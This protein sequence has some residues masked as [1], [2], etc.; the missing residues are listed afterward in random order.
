MASISIN[1]RDFRREV[2]GALAADG[3][4]WE[5]PE[6]V[7]T[8]S[9]KKEIFWR[10]YVRIISE[11]DYDI[12]K[13]NP[14]YVPDFAPIDDV[15]FDSKPMEGLF[16]WINV[17]SGMRGGKI[18]KTVPTI[19]R[20]GKNLGRVSATNPWTQALRDAYSTYN[21]QLKKAAGPGGVNVE[22]YP[23]MLAQVFNDQ[24]N[25]PTIDETHEA[26]VQRKYNGVRVVATLDVTVEGE[27]RVIMYSRR[28]G[29]YPGFT[30]IKA[31]LL[32]ILK[33]YHEEGR[34]LYID[35]ELYKHGIPLQD[36]SG[37][38]RREHR[39]GDPTL[40]YM[41]YDCF[42]SNEPELRFSERMKIRD[43]IFDEFDTEYAVSAETFTVNSHEEITRLYEQFLAEEEEGAM[44][45]FDE[46]YEYS[47][48]ERH[49]KALLK[50]KPTYD[51]EYKI[52]G[53]ETGT[54]G[55][56][57]NALMM[58]CETAEGIPFPVT[59]AA[60][61]PDRIAL[62]RKMT[63]VEP[64]GR[65]HFQNQWES[66]QLI[67]YFDEKSKDNVPQRARTKLEIRAWD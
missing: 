31:E 10:I 30:Y 15:Y 45:R 43:F 41:V 48:N 5:F 28:K 24:K 37:Y 26:F 18:K 34:R 21:R 51:E 39:A 25:L 59:P 58:I 49:C 6:V 63:E 7:S 17:Y 61:I 44:I 4:T 35:G 33:F 50:M 62:A 38:A 1:V 23:P 22:L 54:K 60:E 32:E 12:I 27:P 16:G 56:A 65:S 3:L 36:I 64:N 57:A 2:P 47:Y 53:W 19:V 8:N 11:H 67:V 42:I 46:P 9:H 13:V 52:I 20:T 29:I 40:N 66:K 14:D 55:K